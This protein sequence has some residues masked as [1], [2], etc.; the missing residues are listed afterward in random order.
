M[1]GY[2]YRHVLFRTQ[3]HFLHLVCHPQGRLVLQFLHGTGNPHGG[4]FISSGIQD[5]E[6]LI[7]D[8]NICR[9]IISQES[10]S[11]FRHGCR[12][13]RRKAFIHSHLDIRMGFLLCFTEPSCILCQS[14]PHAYILHRRCL[15]KRIFHIFRQ[16]KRILIVSVR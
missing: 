11:P 9:R 4:I 10:G 6:I 12:I 8:G 1:T 2:F 3:Q 7:H 16:E 13:C 5:I 15:A 14:Q